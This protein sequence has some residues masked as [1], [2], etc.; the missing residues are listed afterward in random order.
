MKLHTSITL[1]VGSFLWSC[2][3][4]SP[5]QQHQAIQMDTAEHVVLA[6][7]IDQQGNKSSEMAY[8]AAAIDDSP[9]TAI[10]IA[11]N[12]TQ[13][14]EGPYNISG[15]FGDG[16]KFVVHIPTVV[17]PE[18]Y[19]GMGHNDYGP[20]YCYSNYTMNLYRWGDATCS[21]IYDCNHQSPPATSSTST[22]SS[23]SPGGSSTST[24][25]SSA[26]TSSDAESNNIALGVGIGI[27]V[28]SFIVAALGTW[29]AQRRYRDHKG[30]DSQNTPDDESVQPPQA[31]PTGPNAEDREAE[32]NG[33]TE[34]PPE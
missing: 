6:N 7:C 11:S 19:A 16:D 25:T 18:Q 32:A 31:A 3:Y 17:S 15:T 29:Y 26:G 12:G 28:P 5:T 27:G 33:R 34:E 4:A 22:I 21:Q 2:V 30:N 20:F 23:I 8:Y 1:S 9:Q 10:T 13:L 24:P 14:W